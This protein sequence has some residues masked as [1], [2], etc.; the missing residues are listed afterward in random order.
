MT[1]PHD[2]TVFV[3]TQSTYILEVSV[4]RVQVTILQPPHAYQLLPA[5]VVV[6]YVNPPLYLPNLPNPL[7]SQASI[8]QPP[9]L[10]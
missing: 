10:A 3:S 4:E 5:P 1:S 2:V 6:R 7:E 9:L 8:I